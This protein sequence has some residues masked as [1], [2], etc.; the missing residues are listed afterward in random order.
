[1]SSTDLP[2]LPAF[3]WPSREALAKHL[4]ECD[5]VWAADEL[6]LGL[7]LPRPA[8]PEAGQVQQP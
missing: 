8:G 7:M 1:M 6:L 4:T 3:V 2:Q 5:A